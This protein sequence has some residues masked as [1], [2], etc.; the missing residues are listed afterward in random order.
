MLNEDGLQRYDEL[1]IVPPLRSLSPPYQRTGTF[2]TETFL[3]VKILQNM[4]ITSFIFDTLMIFGPVAG[5]IPQYMSLKERGFSQV[6]HQLTRNFRTWKFFPSDLF[7]TFGFQHTP[8][9]LLVFERI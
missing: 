9:L 2:S 4:S 7:D 3:C 5:Y 6:H 8:S 1:A